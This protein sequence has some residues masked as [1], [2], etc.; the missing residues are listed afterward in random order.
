MASWR[1]T[2][3]DRLA[4]SP[5]HSNTSAVASPRSL[6]VIVVARV[7]SWAR[8][9]SLHLCLA[10]ASVPS[11]A[12][13]KRRIGAEIG[14]AEFVASGTLSSVS[15]AS[16]AEL[17]GQPLQLQASLRFLRQAQAQ[18][19]PSHRMQGHEPCG[20]SCVEAARLLVHPVNLLREGPGRGRRSESV[21]DLTLAAARAVDPGKRSR[22]ST[23]QGH[24]VTAARP[25]RKVLL[26]HRKQW[27]LKSTKPKPKPWRNW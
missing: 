16:G 9:T 26:L 4:Q 27:I 12:A 5:S 24:Q 18:R 11:Q 23:N 7:P 22:R 3:S 1:H 8:V 10:Q 20:K 2:I 25:V 21:V 13:A 14:S 15:S 19:E 17:L 6:V